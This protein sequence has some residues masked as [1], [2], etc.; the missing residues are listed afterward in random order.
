MSE[1]QATILALFIFIGGPFIAL[2]SLGAWADSAGCHHQWEKS[3]FEADWGIIQGC[4]IKV[5]G[6]WIPSDNYRDL[7]AKL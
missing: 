7:G 1:L 5:D 3:G 4:L 2:L 6:R